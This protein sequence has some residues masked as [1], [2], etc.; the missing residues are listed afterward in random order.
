MLVVDRARGQWE[1]RKFRLKLSS[2]GAGL[3]AVLA[4]GLT[5]VIAR[6]LYGVTATGPITFAAAA[7]GLLAVG[8][9]PCYIPARRATRVDPLTALRHE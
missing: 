3:G 4:V 6:F 9:L 8:L 5:R 7:S 1:D 2:L